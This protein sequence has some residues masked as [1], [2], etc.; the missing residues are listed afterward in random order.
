MPTSLKAYTVDF[1][2]LKLSIIV[3]AQIVLISNGN[4][5][6]A[7][8]SD[9]SSPVVFTNANLG[10]GLLYGGFGGNLEIGRGHFSAFLSTGYATKRVVDN[11]TISPSVNFSGG[12][13]YYFDVKSDVIYPRFGIGYGWITNYY[14]D[15][16]MTSD[17]DQNVHGLS[18]HIGTQVYSTEGLVFN[19]DIGMATK[20]AITNSQNHPNF[21]PFYIRPN[22]G[23]GFDLTRL[24]SKEGKTRHVKNNPI[25]PFGS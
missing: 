21:F 14:S 10:F 19:F 12:L 7:Q 16:L 15:G 3:F 11:T 1:I 22:I 5:A 24:F 18:A 8:S 13:R 23:I 20:H 9:K 4:L 6:K 17:Y 2:S 25:D